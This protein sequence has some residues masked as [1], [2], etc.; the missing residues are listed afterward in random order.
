MVLSKIN[1]DISYPEIKSVDPSDLKQEANLYQ[2]DVNDVEIIIAVGNSKNNFEDKN[3]LYFPIYLV[4]HNNKVVQIGVYEILSSDYLTYLDD[5]NNLN[6]EKLDDP[7][8]YNFSTK[9]MLMKLRME[10]EIT[11]R[12]S[13]EKKGKSKKDKE[14]K[15]AVEEVEKGEKEDKKVLLSTEQII[16]EERSDI[17]VL[18]KGV[19]ILALL[20]EENKKSAKEIMKEYKAET[21]DNWVQKYMENK[22]YGIFDTDS[23]GDCFFATIRDAFSSIA[24]ETS[25][26][27]I[28]RRLAGE[29]DEAFFTNTKGLYDNLNNSLLEDTTKIKELGFQYDELQRKFTNTLDRN[30]RKLISDAAKKVKEQHDRLVNE[31]KVTSKIISEFKYMKGIDTVDKMKKKVRTCEFWA[32]TWAISTLERILNIKT[33]LLSSEAYKAKDFTNVLQ[34]GQ[35]NDS[36]LENRGVFLPEYYIIQEYTGSHYKLISY[37]NKKIFKF[38]EI[39]YELKKKIAEKCLEGETGPFTLIPDFQQFKT[40]IQKGKSGGGNN[41]EEYY[42]DLSDAK[43]RGLYDDSIIFMFY[44]KSND[45]SLPGKG[46]GEKISNDKIKDFTELATIPQWR[47]KL[48]DFWIQPFTLDNHKWASVEHFYQG[49]KFKRLHPDFYL[50]FSL[51]SGTEFSKDAAMAKGAGGTDGKYKDTLLR[52]LEVQIDP[53]FFGTRDEKVKN[54]ARHAKFT[55]NDDLKKLLLATNNAKLVHQQKGTKPIVFEDLMILRD[56]LRRSDN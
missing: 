42:E 5:N 52:P 12:R 37:K 22:N 17:F 6:V 53:E 11:L 8:I 43:L 44:S 56:K 51:D 20:E 7:L 4:K 26:E 36:I 9:E 46:P 55:Q 14:E 33:I 54:S 13:G 15:E 18:T 39:P 49:S 24:Q 23:N 29:I 34:C 32:D 47:R 38:S 48:S 28:R 27:K 50:S 40:T 41:V 1:D 31:K 35:L 16:P 2:I 3:I 19:P 10:P 45:K 30:D 21:T 25:V